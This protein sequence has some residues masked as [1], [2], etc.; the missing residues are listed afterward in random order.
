MVMFYMITPLALT[1]S[2]SI[3]AFVV[4]NIYNLHLLWQLVTFEGIRERL[5]HALLIVKTFDMCFC[6]KLCLNLCLLL[7]EF[8]C[9]DCF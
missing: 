5:R 8:C 6:G 3:I 9:Y 1:I 2:D 4:N 7:L